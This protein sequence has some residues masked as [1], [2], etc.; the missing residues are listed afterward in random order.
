ML[1]LLFVVVGGG[2]RVP[3]SIVFIFIWGWFKRRERGERS[4]RRSKEGR[5]RVGRGRG[6]GRRR[7]GRGGGRGGGGRGGIKSIHISG[8][9][10]H[11]HYLQS[12]GEGRRGERRGDEMMKRTGFETVVNKL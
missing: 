10:L 4:S 12:G 3:G 7:R 9:R 6:R 5:K 1:L 8:K 11:E 2:L